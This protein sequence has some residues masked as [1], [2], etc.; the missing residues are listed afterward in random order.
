MQ[1]Y[2]CLNKCKNHF[3]TSTS[4][5]CHDN[6]GVKCGLGCNCR[7]HVGYFLRYWAWSMHWFKTEHSGVM[8]CTR[9]K[10]LSVYLYSWG[11]KIEGLYQFPF[12]TNLTISFNDISVLCGALIIC[13]ISGI[14]PG[15][16]RVHLFIEKQI[17][18]VPLI[19][20]FIE[21]FAILSQYIF[22]K[23]DSHTNDWCKWPRPEWFFYE[24]IRF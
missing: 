23:P 18:H 2:C 15:E 16:Y 4:V 20:H 3:V 17:Y 8:S 19:F 1:F 13:H 12:M 6:R 21:I 9:L 22:F 11:W 14:G 7:K 10:S 24:F 5:I